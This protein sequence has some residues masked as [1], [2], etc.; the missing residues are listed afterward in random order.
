MHR[1]FVCVQL[2]FLWVLKLAVTRWATVTVPPSFT[3]SLTFL[4][5]KYTTFLAPCHLTVDM[6]PHI[7]A[8]TILP[9]ATGW[10]CLSNKNQQQILNIFY[11]LT[12]TCQIHHAFWLPLLC[13]GPFSGE[14]CSQRGCGILG[15]WDLM[16]LA[17]SAKG[18]THSGACLDKSPGVW[19][20]EE[21]TQGVLTPPDMLTNCSVT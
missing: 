5:W 10:C 20:K 4:F 9:V 18:K 14:C 8:S 7:C 1:A 19:R 12:L 16:L 17:L 11:S 13:R 2:L 3:P 15:Q 6:C 21:Y